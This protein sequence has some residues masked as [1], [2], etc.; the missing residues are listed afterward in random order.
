MPTQEETLLEVVFAGF[1]AFDFLTNPPRL[2]PA[3]TGISFLRVSPT[4]PKVIS[5]LAELVDPEELEDPDPEEPEE[6]AGAGA[7]AGAGSGS[8]AGSGGGFGGDMTSL[9]TSKGLTTASAALVISL[10]TI[11]L[12]NFF[13]LMIN[14]FAQDIYRA[15]LLTDQI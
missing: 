5:F 10:G 2:K 15:W 4:P 12:T 13:K 3:E 14:S 8:G 6:G 9:M 7:G 1:L 11:F